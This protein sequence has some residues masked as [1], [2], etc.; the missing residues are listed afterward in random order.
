[1]AGARTAA[2][3]GARAK[4]FGVQF[5]D[6]HIHPPLL[7]AAVNEIRVCASLA[8]TFLPARRLQP[9][10]RLLQAYPIVLKNHLRAE[11]D[12]RALKKLLTEDEIDALGSVVHKPQF[13]LGRLRA[14]MHA[15]RKAGVGD[16][17]RELLLKCTSSLGECLGACERIVQTPIPLHYSRHTS[18][19]VTMYVSTLP[20]LL[21]GALGALT[22]PVMGALSWALFGILEIGHLIE[23]P[24]SSETDDDGQ[25]LLPL[26]DL[27][28]TIRRDVVEVARHADIAEDHGLE[29]SLPPMVVVR[30]SAGDAPPREQSGGGGARKDAAPPPPAAAPAAAEAAPTAAPTAAAPAAPAAAPE[31]AERKR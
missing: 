27:C 1:M 23:E 2:I 24:F 7:Q 9:L 21:V 31:G 3:L 28:R 11:R 17:E 8:C 6:A 29:V 18:R 26:N 10:L 25:M 16:K 5:S 4:F 13:V 20:F 19:F 15:S 22:L 30:S 12:T 14:L